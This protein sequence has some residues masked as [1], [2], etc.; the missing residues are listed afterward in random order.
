MLYFLKLSRVNGL[1]LSLLV[2]YI[3]LCYITFCYIS[4][5]CYIILDKIKLV[6]LLLSV[7][8]YICSPI[9]FVSLFKTLE[10]SCSCRCM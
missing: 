7:L 4:P 9:I 6:Y 10:L 1:L 8:F 5:L 3:M 2:Y